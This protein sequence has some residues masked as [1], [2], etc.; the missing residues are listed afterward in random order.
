MRFKRFT[1]SWLSPLLGVHVGRNPVSGQRFAH[2]AFLPFCGIDIEFAPYVN[3]TVK[4]RLE[5]NSA[6]R[7]A[8]E[9]AIAVTNQCWNCGGSGLRC[10]EYARAR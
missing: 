8:A 6:R 10:C 5:E 9:T 7:V 2:I 3:D 4:A 1:F